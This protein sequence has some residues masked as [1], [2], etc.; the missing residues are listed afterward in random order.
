MPTLAAM[1]LSD[2]LLAKGGPGSGPQGGSHMLSP[3]AYASL[4]RLAEDKTPEG[5]VAAQ[6][7]SEYDARTNSQR[8]GTSEIA[9]HAEELSARAMQNPTR[10]AHMAAQLAHREAATSYRSQPGNAVHVQY[11]SDRSIEH[12]NLARTYEK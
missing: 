12:R 2:A 3:S 7:L 6:R 10:A 1:L 8:A 11:H 4:R 9:T 5:R